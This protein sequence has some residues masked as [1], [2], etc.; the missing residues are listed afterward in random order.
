MTVI[1]CFFDK[2]HLTVTRKVLSVILALFLI[3]CLTGCE[4]QA[5]I[6]PSLSSPEEACESLC[7]ALRAYDLTSANGCLL[8]PVDLEAFDITGEQ[9]LAPFIPFFAE[10]AGKLTY[11]I[12]P[13]SASD[14]EAHV[15]VDYRYADASSVLKDAAKAYL[16]AAVSMASQGKED[17][18]IKAS[19]PDILQECAKNVELKESTLTVE[20]D[21]V[22]G[23]GEW[24]IV[25][26]PGDLVKLLTNDLFLYTDEV[27][28]DLKP[29]LPVG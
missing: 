1:E 22:Q 7:Q 24:K 4:K 5:V 18:E 29:Y 12:H 8:Y 10:W 16:A 26:L 19:L 28:A 17:G 23:G 15:T 2:E 20:Y 27:A 21:L 14:G 3:F 6:Q 25:S 11:T 13:A 9:L